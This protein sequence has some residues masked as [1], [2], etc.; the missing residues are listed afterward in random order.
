MPGHPKRPVGRN[1]TTARNLKARRLT[2][3]CNARPHRLSDAQAALRASVSASCGQDEGIR[4]DEALRSFLAL[5]A[6]D[7]T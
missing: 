3:L 1:G 5:N 7:G 6:A 2:N 4:E